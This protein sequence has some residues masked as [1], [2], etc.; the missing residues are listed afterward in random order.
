MGVEGLGPRVQE[1]S[2]N[3]GVTWTS[4]MKL[5]L[6]YVP[7]KCDVEASLN[8][9]SDGLFKGNRGYMRCRGWRTSFR[10]LDF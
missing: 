6:G 8:T 5:K 1:Y 2:P 4:D 9:K 10:V 7:G 3:N